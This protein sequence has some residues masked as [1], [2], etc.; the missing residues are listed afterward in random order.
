MDR[1]RT[2]CPSGRMPR[3]TV[4]LQL[5]DSYREANCAERRRSSEAEAPLGA[6]A[7]VF[8]PAG[9]PGRGG[10]GGSRHA[11]DAGR[12]AEAV[13]HLAQHGAADQAAEEVAGEV[14]A[15]R[16]AAVGRWRRGR[17]SRWPSPGRRRCRR[18]PAPGRA[19]RPAGSG[20]SSSGRP[21]PA[22][23]ERA[24]EASAAC[25]SGRRP[26]RRAAW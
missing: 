25:R 23:A 21:A 10:Q 19:A 26:G 22:T 14:E 8:E 24:P 2:G 4:Q 13:E 20:R 1:F 11:G 7:P 9:Q 12:P 17:R 18:R 3:S 5:M 16:R 6:G 15:A